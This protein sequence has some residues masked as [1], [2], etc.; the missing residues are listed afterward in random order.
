MNFCQI[1]FRITNFIIGITV[2]LCFTAWLCSEEQKVP[3]ESDSEFTQ[4]EQSDHFFEHVQQLENSIPE[5]SGLASRWDLLDGQD[6][7]LE[8]VP[9]LRTFFGYKGEDR[10]ASIV[11]KLQELPW[12]SRVDSFNDDLVEF[13]KVFVWHSFFV[14]KTQSYADLQRSTHE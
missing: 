7:F 5:L 4:S 9:R 10:F 14:H 2:V 8:I 12:K 6:L 13:S 3:S 11:E 1:S